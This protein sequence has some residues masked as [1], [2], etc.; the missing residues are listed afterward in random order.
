[1]AHWDLRSLADD[2][3]ALRT[4]LHLL[5]GEGDRAVPPRQARQ[6]AA[7][8]PGTTL[9]LLPRLG[10]LAH[11]EAPAAVVGW[12]RALASPDASDPGLRV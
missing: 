10:H 8:R 5:V 6:V 2:L 9:T 1:M 11:E 4:P 7:A 3:P 12:L